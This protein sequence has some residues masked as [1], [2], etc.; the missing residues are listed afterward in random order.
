MTTIWWNKE[1]DKTA[2]IQK[3]KETVNI[4]SEK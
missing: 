3:L 4:S 1:A 2:L